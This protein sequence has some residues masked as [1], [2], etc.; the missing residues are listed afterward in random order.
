VLVGRFNGFNNGRICLSSAELADA[1]H[2]WN[3][4]ANAKAIAE[5]VGR[6][7][8]V[9]TRSYPRGV[10]LS[11]EYRLTFASSGPEGKVRQA[12]EEYRDWREGDAGTVSKRAVG[13]KTL[14]A[15]ANETAVSSSAIADEEKLSV[16]FVADEARVADGKLPKFP[17]PSFAVI[18]E[19]IVSHRGGSNPS[20]RDTP[21][22]AGGPRAV[23]SAAPPAE[24]LRER[25]LAHVA[26]HGRGSQGLLAQQASIPGGTL[27]KFL[28]HNGPLSEHAR[29]RLTCAFPKAEAAALQLERTAR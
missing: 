2:C 24:E 6:G 11:P 23:V 22:I 9:V 10:R 3:Y 26:K 1:L 12:T 20:R 21:E 18:A 15:I 25:V 28:R 17:D 5:L 29:V 4:A 19:H 16:A 7:L 8:V 27:C 14:P 13:K